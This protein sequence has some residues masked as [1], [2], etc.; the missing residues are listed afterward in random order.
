MRA[1]GCGKVF[2]VG[3]GPGDPG[4]LTLR[5]AEVLAEAEVL[6][7]D[8]LVSEEIVAL[9]PP[10]CE[11]V[12]VGKRFGNHALDQREIV[13]LMLRF[14]LE[15]RRV[16]RLKGGDPFVFG[17]GGEELAALGAA[18]IETELVPGI[19]SVTAAPASAG[20]PLTHRGVS[21]GFMVVTG[22]E[23]ASHDGT[24]VDWRHVAA[25]SG[26]IVVLMGL[27]AL[28]PICDRLTGA[29]MAPSTPVCVIENATLP[30]QRT[31]EGTLETIVQ[32]VAARAL[33]GPATIV[34]GEAVRLRA[35]NGG[36]RRRAGV[37]CV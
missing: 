18:G 26:T 12:F 16:V 36:S 3:A 31:I 6:L 8:A 32:C 34:I 10:A 17:R 21:A 11:R 4:L 14:A 7:Y 37:A 29:G 24:R 25:F 23:D 5:A 1:N 20:I 30:S 22:H 27:R 19:S 35:A 28:A 9:V 2:V 13:A 15:R 33:D